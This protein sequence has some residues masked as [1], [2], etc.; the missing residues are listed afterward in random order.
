[1]KP[2][3]LAPHTSGVIKK[4]FD[5]YLNPEFYQ[6]IEG[7]VEVAKAV[8]RLPL[9]VICF[10]G[11]T[12][13]GRLVAIEAAKNLVP[14]ILE[15]GGKCPVIIDESASLEAAVN[16]TLNGKYLNCGQTCIGVDHVYVHESKK[17]QFKELLMRK[18]DLFFGGGQNLEEDGNYGKIVNKFHVERLEKL[19]KDSHG[20]NLLYGGTVKK[21]IRFI[22]PTVIEEPKKDSLMMQEEIFGPIMPVFY[23]SSLPDLVQEINRRAKPLVVYM[24]SESSKNINLVKDNTFSGA[25]VSNE[26]IMQMANK[27]LPFGGVGGSGQGRLHGKHGFQTFSNPKSVALMSSM[28]SFPTN[29]R[30]PPYTEDKKSFLRKLMKV[31]F[32]TPGQIGKCLTI[33]LLLVTAIVL[34]GVLIPRA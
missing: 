12:T 25:F 26:T 3:E 7:K 14:C 30:Y 28:D 29:R 16:R 24:F 6:C 23:F 19:L 33:F 11:S 34:C 22:S 27:D 18:L 9:D 21:D 4:L 1:M 15:L 31:A 20:G 5:K 10:T 8:S 32:I 13:T 2:S 17:E